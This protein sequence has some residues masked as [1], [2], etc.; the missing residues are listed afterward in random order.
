MPLKVIPITVTAL[1]LVGDI[2]I[3]NM[4]L[5]VVIGG[6]YSNCGRGAPE[7][8]DRRLYPFLLRCH[9]T[10]LTHTIA[11]CSM[12]F[13]TVG[14]PTTSAWAANLAYLYMLPLCTFFPSLYHNIVIQSTLL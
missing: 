14:W 8:Y 9:G 11:H 7:L 6:W 10:D 12:L 3:A 2:N 13:P 1:G 4:D 5:Q